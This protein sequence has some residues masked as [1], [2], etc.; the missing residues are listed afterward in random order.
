MSINPGELLELAR[1]L[2]ADVSGRH[3]WDASLRRGVSTAYYAIFHEVTALAVEHVLP[4]APDAAKNH[5]RRTWTHG[6]LAGAA[7]MINDRAHVLTNNPAAPP[8]KT[9]M[10][11]GPL[12]DLASAD[13]HIV[14]AAH[15]FLE[16]QG[17]RHAADYDHAAMFDK[18]SLLSACQDA[19]EARTALRDASTS[20]REAFLALLLVQRPDLRGR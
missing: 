12:V 16:L 13:P 6:E 17:Q 9:D 2:A 4:S 19:D 1:A 20:A 18:A 10:Q 5:V 14:E 11:W 7:T 15:I 8:S 3:S